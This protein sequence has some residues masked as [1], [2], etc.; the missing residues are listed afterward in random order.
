L[1]GVGWADAEAGDYRAALAPWIELRGRDLFDSAVQESLL[2]VPYAFSQLGA[3]KQAADY[4]VDAI[5]AFDDEIGH[6]DVSIDAI[7]SGRLIDDLL[8]REAADG[9]GW[10]WRLD[11]IPESPESRYLYELMATNRFQEGLKTYRDLSYLTDNLDAWAESLS[12]FDDILDTRQRAYR[13][14]LPVVDASLER[15]DLDE[16]ARRRVQLES[17]LL[18]IERSEDVVALGTAEQQT[19]WRDLTEMEGKLDLLGG[20]ARGEELSNK[21]RFLKGLLLWDLRRDYRARL[22]AEQRSLR[23]LDLELKQARRSHTEV[24]SARNEWPDQFA[25]LTTRIGALTPRVAALQGTAQATLARQR[26][27]LQGIAVEELEA[28]RARL[29]TYLVQA[30]FSLA[31]IYDRASADARPR[32]EPVLAEGLE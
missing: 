30:R 31:S 21:Q 8:E 5:E 25:D 27:F 11:D 26:E 18:E 3:A 2:A 15:M 29:N 16:M 1:L 7:N 14:R 22:W 6:L 13:E 12:I 4:Y 24:E 28:Q 20:D 23:E 17:R 32:P 9:S 19:L 10:F